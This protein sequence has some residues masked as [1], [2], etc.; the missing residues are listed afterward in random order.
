[1]RQYRL[2]SVSEKNNWRFII[3]MSKKIAAA[4]LIGALG[5]F[6]MCTG[7]WMIGY[8]QTSSS[9]SATFVKMTANQIPLWRISASMF[10]AFIGALVLVFGAYNQKE[11][12]NEKNINLKKFYTGSVIASVSVWVFLHF[13]YCG[14]IAIYKMLSDA[15]VQDAYELTSQVVKLFTPLSMLAML[16]MMLPYLTFM[17]SIFAKKTLF[18]RWMGFF[19]M[20]IYVLAF[21][22]LVSFIKN[23]AF[24]NGLAVA[25]NNM[26]IGLW[27]VSSAIYLFCHK[28][29]K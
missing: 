8:I 20:L 25:S 12:I 24:G 4:S 1:M 6:L 26:A 13:M 2:K 29:D 7:D 5:A 16:P 27:F 3:Y 17:I 28:E 21:N 23:T 14:N 10:F 9:D 18:P 22:I 19:Y 11:L 15:G